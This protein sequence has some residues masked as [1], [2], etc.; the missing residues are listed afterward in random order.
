MCNWYMCHISYHHWACKEM[1]L[2]ITG[3]EEDGVN[4]E[5][6]NPEDLYSKPEDALTKTS[7]RVKGSLGQLWH[8]V[9]GSRSICCFRPS[10]FL[11]AVFMLLED[12]SKHN[13]YLKSWDADPSLGN[14]TTSFSHCGFSVRKSF[15]F[16]M[17]WAK[18]KM[19]FSPLLQPSATCMECTSL[20]MWSWN[21]LFWTRLGWPTPPL[22]RIIFS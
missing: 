22:S 18:W 16:T 5:D 21:P 19:A 10:F 15:R 7:R 2:G 8:Q 9:M 20:A 4:N 1:E 3:G 13:L 14:S 17:R 11:V 6:A 12:L